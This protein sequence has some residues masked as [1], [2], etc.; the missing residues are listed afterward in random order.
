MDLRNDSING[1][2]G[3]VRG[4]VAESANVGVIFE[5]GHFGDVGRFGGAVE[6]W[7]GAGVEDDGEVEVRVVCRAVLGV[8]V[9]GDEGWR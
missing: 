7:A 9:S 1:F 5:S 6:A 4:D 8:D 2:V 3:V